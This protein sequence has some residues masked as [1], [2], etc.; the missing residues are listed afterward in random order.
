[1]LDMI[2][3]GFSRWLPTIG[4]HRL[5]ALTPSSC[6]LQELCDFPLKSLADMFISLAG[7][8]T[9]GHQSCLLYFLATGSCERSGAGQETVRVHAQA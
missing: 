4:W 8:R 2:C 1:M 9:L 5:W 3:H 6:S 7:G